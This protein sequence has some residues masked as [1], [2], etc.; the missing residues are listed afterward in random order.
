MTA[1]D[2]EHAVDV[3]EVDDLRD[4]GER[5]TER[6]GIAVDGDD[7]EPEGP[8]ALDRSPLVT[9]GADEEDGL[10]AHEAERY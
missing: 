3:L 2:L 9:T 7:S 4:V 8:G 5:E 10:P 6:V 1:R